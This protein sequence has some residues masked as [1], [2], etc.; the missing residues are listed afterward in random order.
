MTQSTTIE[1]VECSPITRV[2]L[3]K[4]EDGDLCVELAWRA[5]NKD[6]RGAFGIVIQRRSQMA[7]PI[8]V[9]AVDYATAKRAYDQLVEL[10]TD[11]PRTFA[12]AA[13][14]GK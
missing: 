7:R 12:T 3:A 6:Q 8:S 10:V 2:S 1:E 14:G 4:Y 11:E 13:Q 9:W 5:T